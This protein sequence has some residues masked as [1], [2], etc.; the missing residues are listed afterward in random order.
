ISSN[1]QEYLLERYMQIHIIPYNISGGSS[2]FSKAEIKDI[3]SYFRLIVNPDDDR[4]F[5]LVINTPKREVGSATV[6]K[7]GEYESQQHCSFFH[8]MDS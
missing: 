8:T 7:L 1:Y 4:A 5:L 6:H 2:F 3:I